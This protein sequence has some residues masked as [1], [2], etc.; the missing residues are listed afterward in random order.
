M[1]QSSKYVHFD[2]IPTFCFV[3]L[4][5]SSTLGIPSPVLSVNLLSVIFF[6]P[7]K[8]SPILFLF[9]IKALLY[10]GTLCVY[11]SFAL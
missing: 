1:R 8:F 3:F 11:S 2:I 9:Y 10:I 4:L 6:R 5:L 7:R